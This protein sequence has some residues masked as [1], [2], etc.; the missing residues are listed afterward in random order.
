MADNT[1]KPPLICQVAYEN[2][3]VVI[4]KEGKRKTSAKCRGCVRVVQGTNSTTSNYIS[5]TKT[6]HP[7]LRVL[8]QSVNKW[9]IDVYVVVCWKVCF[10]VAS[11]AKLQPMMMLFIDSEY[12][13][14]YVNIILSS[15]WWRIQSYS[16]I[17]SWSSIIIVQTGWDF[18][19]LWF[20]FR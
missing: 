17:R 13:Y 12:L 3:S 8:S 11:L 16:L 1:P 5:H 15:T 9:F 14:L 2:Y 18:H 7:K 4:E 10:N 19:F 6:A 20:I